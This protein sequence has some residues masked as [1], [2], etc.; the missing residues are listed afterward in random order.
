MHAIR[1]TIKQ[2]AGGNGGQKLGK[3]GKKRS[4]TAGTLSSNHSSAD[5]SEQ[6]VTLG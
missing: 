6:K 4:G 5:V 1:E 3:G 2:Q